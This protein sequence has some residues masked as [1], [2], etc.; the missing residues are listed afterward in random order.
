MEDL[1]Q[2]AYVRG[3][4]KKMRATHTAQ[5]MRVI[6]HHGNPVMPVDWDRYLHHSTAWVRF[7]LCKHE[8]PSSPTSDDIFVADIDKIRVIMPSQTTNWR[9]EK[10]N[11]P[12]RR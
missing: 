4:L 2:G 5:A 3:H 12:S 9:G 7:T 6:D 8:M 10:G 1:I 11:V